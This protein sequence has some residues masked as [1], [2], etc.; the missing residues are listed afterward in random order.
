[1]ARLAGCILSLLVVAAAVFGVIAYRA[2]QEVPEFYTEAVSVDPQRQVEASRKM[3]SQVTML[4][5]EAQRA[6]QWS[7]VF[8]TQQINGWLAVDLEEKH[9]DLVPPEIQQPRVAITPDEFTLALTYQDGQVATVL[10]LAIEGYVAE[11]N[12]LA[13]RIRDVRAGTLPLPMSEVMRRISE[14]AI[15]AELPLR[16]TKIEGDP[17]ALVTVTPTLQNGRR[18]RL[19]R[20][21]L[22]QAEILVEGTTLD[23][24]PLPPSVSPHNPRLAAH[25]QGSSTSQR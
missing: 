1:M 8:T 19:E 22:G 6:G 20:L 4:Y 3:E 9:P 7:A 15:E 23:N 13:L 25:P 18:L 24:Q 10:S 16:W 11:E 14:T 5:S 17:V 21:Q 12:V 2:S